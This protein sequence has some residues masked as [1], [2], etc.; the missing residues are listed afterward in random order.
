MGSSGIDVSKRYGVGS[1][2]KGTPPD[3]TEVSKAEAQG[4]NQENPKT[5]AD[6]TAKKQE[7]DSGNNTT[8]IT[9]R[10]EPE[11]KQDDAALIRE[12]Q[13][14][15]AVNQELRKS[16]GFANEYQRNRANGVSNEYITGIKE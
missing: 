8:T 2:F 7:N 9:P 15:H 4:K 12:A 11:A 1:F 16:D 3:T 14:R 5:E 6:Q 13:Q 10:V